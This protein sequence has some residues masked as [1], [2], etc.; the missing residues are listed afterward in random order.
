MDRAMSGCAAEVTYEPPRAH[1]LALRPCVR[2]GAEL[3][4][5][6]LADANPERRVFLAQR[7]PMLTRSSRDVQ[8]STTSVLYFRYGLRAQPPA[9]CT[10][11][12]RRAPCP[13]APRT[14]RS[15][16]AYPASGLPHV[17]P[18]VAPQVPADCEPVR[19]HDHRAATWRARV[20]AALLAIRLPPAAV[21]RLSTRQANRKRRRRRRRRRRR[22]QA[23]CAGRLPRTSS[24]RIARMQAVASRRRGAA[25]G[26]PRQ[27]GEC[28]RMHSTAR[29]RR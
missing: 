27:C 14:A 4:G 17:P 18:T 3:R 26:G 19:V 12:R 29:V 11:R 1:E 23:D 25:A 24:L 28:H 7:P 21:L 15:L 6:W 9:C 8:Y 2:F 20:A 13:E 10:C 16:Y 5:A 22:P